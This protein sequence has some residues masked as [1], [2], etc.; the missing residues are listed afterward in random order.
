MKNKFGQPQE[1]LG[2]IAKNIAAAEKQRKELRF[3]YNFNDFEQGKIQVLKNDEFIAGLQSYLLADLAENKDKKTQLLFRLGEGALAKEITVRERALALLS[4]ATE[5]QLAQNEKANILVLAHGL[6][7]WLEFEEEFIPGFSVLNKRLEDVLLWL[8]DNACWV[9]A[10]ESVSLLHR[11]KSGSLKKSRAIKSLTSKT[12]Q[13]LEKKTILEKLTDG[14]L[15]ENEQQPLFQNILHS[16]GSISAMYLLDRVSHS[17][18]RTDRLDLLNLI[19]SFGNSAVPAL[20]DCLKSDPPWAVVKNI[21]Y[22]IS[23]IKIDAHYVLVAR[24]FS[25]FDERVQHEMIRCVLKL[26]GPMMKPRLIKGLSSVE[27]RLK[28]HILRLLVEKEDNDQDVLE[29]ILDLI[30]KRISY[31]RQSGHDLQHA[32]IEALKK[33]P[34]TKSIVQLEEMGDVFSR[35]KGTEQLLLHIDEALMVLEPKIRHSMQGPDY[36]KDMVSFAND[37]FQKQLASEKVRKLEEEVQVLVRAGDIHQAGELIYNQATFAAKTTDYS[38]A[39]LLRD[40]L[41]EVNPKA[42]NQAIELGKFIE[43]QKNTS[44][45]SHHLEIWSEL[46]EDMTTEEFNELHHSLRQENYHKDDLIVQSGEN[47]NNLYFLNSGYISLRCMVGGREIFLKRMQPSNVLGGDQFF[48]NS[49]WTVTLRALCEIQVHVLDHAVLKKIAVEHPGIEYKLRKY[50]QKHTPVP[51]LLKMS[52]GDRREYPRY[53]VVLQTRNV[54]MDPYG[55]MEKRSFNGELFDISEQGMAFTIR[56]SNTNKAR[57]LLG[58]HIKTTIIVGEEELPVQNG[59]VVGVRLF[60]PIMQDFS[61]HVKLSKKIDVTFYKK[62]LLHFRK[63]Q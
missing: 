33:F 34:C 61:V 44:I 48:S 10:E 60:A 51:E 21:I 40:R 35:Q 17:D 58:R 2:N 45:T 9:E 13:K 29:A 54:L 12:L 7:N 62:I 55:S 31:S 30:K 37:P 15:L 27:D 43:N 18:N 6:G 39:E 16:I 57:L 59:V 25:H 50:C 8:M 19:S 41:L 11:I 32:F 20:K 53:P 3:V 4:F 63:N 47:D 52:G 46:Y 23:E 22:L 5:L 56:I 36:L 1:V 26:G 42:L 49:V 38:V 14:Y 28:I 24:Y